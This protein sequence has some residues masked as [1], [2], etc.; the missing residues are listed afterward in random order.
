MGE[1]IWIGERLIRSDGRTNSIVLNLGNFP[2][3]VE[4]AEAGKT[5]RVTVLD[6]DSVRVEV[7]DE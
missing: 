7:I 3:L 6:D 4:S 5:A 1:P 2:D